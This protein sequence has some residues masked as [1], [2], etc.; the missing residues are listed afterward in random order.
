MSLT[1]RAFLTTAGGTA[2]AC[3][4]GVSTAGCGF[5]V[6][7]APLIS[8]GFS[9]SQGRLLLE[10]GQVGHLAAIGGS[11]KVTATS[12]LKVCIV[13]ASNNEYTAFENR[14]AHGG[15]ELEYQPD[16]RELRCTSFGHSRYDLQGNVLRGPAKGPLRMLPT[17]LVDKVLEVAMA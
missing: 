10:L 13:R 11:V 1:R 5:G 8:T 4:A 15:Q 7:K 14:C 16:K 2:C 12:G 6:S 9:E 3:V 17:K